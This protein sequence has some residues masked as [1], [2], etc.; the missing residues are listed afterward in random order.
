[1]ATALPYVVLVRGGGVGGWGRKR[2]GCTCAPVAPRTTTSFL[3]AVAMAIVSLGIESV[4]FNSFF[5]LRR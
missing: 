2:R 5:V 3:F 1:M 4:L